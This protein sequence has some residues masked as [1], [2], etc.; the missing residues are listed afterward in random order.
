M[1]DR[2]PDP[3]WLRHRALDGGPIRA[4]DRGGIRHPTESEVSQHLAAGS[5][6]HPTEAATHP[7]AARSGG[8][9][10]MAGVRLAAHQKK[11]RR[12]GAHIA[13]MDESG[14]PKGL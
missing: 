4:T 2:G 12:Q 8:H 10:R 1:V 7:P 13:L 5:G 9:R 3:P 14:L 11:A 6:V